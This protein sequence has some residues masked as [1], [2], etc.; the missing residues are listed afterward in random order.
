[1]D[2]WLR[3][4]IPHAEALIFILMLSGAPQSVDLKIAYGLGLPADVSLIRFS[5][6]SG[7]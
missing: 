7:L 4:T 5:W 3:T 6:N 2:S 1:M